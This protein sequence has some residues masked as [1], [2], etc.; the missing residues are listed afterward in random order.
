MASQ[1]QAHL[2]TGASR[3]KLEKEL[4]ELVD[5]AKNIKDES[6]FQQE[7]R[8]KKFKAKNHTT[9]QT[10]K[11]PIWYIFLDV[12][13][14]LK[15]Y[16]ECIYW[17]YKIL[18]DVRLC[19]SSERLQ[20]FYTIVISFYFL[21][22]FENVFKYGE[23]YLAISMP[24]MTSVEQRGM[25]SSLLYLMQDASRKLN[26]IDEFQ[27]PKEILKL[28]V[29]RYNAKE[30]EKNKLLQS[31]N[32]CIKMQTERGN[33]KGAKKTL[34]HLKL[35]S[36][37]SMHSNDVIKAM[38]NEDYGKFFP[39]NNLL[40]KSEVKEQR[41]LEADFCKRNSDHDS[42]QL[43]R[44]K[45]D[46]YWF[47][48]RICWQKQEIVMNLGE[49]PSNFEWGYLALNI[50]HDITLHLE[51]LLKTL[52]KTSEEIAD[53]A[54]KLYNHDMMEIV[55]ITLLLAD[56]D[57]LNRENLFSQLTK[58][59]YGGNWHMDVFNVILSAQRNFLNLDVQKVMPFLDFCLRSF[60]EGA[61]S[62]KLNV[63]KVPLSRL[64]NSLTITNHFGNLKNTLAFQ[65]V[66]V[67]NRKF[68]KPGELP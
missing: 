29:L 63:L 17:C 58:K 46:I 13:V 7:N 23:K 57:H 11:L 62:N 30:I 4:K 32:N 53:A 61:T 8:Y 39:L 36:L 55:G 9:I 20:A 12:L 6:V 48:S 68:C 22:D 49:L 5:L 59:I 24:A 18:E 21:D 14:E 1:S 65:P 35:F 2:N 64:K 42:F 47:I 41:K 3:S 51:L 31:Y 33:F 26:R 19:D 34:K 66:A 43:Y 45:V 54:A 37:N 52:N 16:K 10:H 27:Y 40:N 44:K 67:H 60:N 56:N 50:L 38:E 25:R 28:D 15:F